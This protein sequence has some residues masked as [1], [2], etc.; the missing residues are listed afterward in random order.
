MSVPTPDLQSDVRLIERS[1]A[2][3]FVSRADV[4]KRTSELQDAA[5]KAEWIEI[6]ATDSS[7][8]DED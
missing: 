2:K 7:D 4:A 1:L 3:G 5:D 6:D 8:S